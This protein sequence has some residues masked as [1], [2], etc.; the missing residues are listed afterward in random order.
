MALFS[1]CNM[2]QQ[3]C[4]VIIKHGQIETSVNRDNRYDRA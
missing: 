4:I 3:V 2:C 1:K